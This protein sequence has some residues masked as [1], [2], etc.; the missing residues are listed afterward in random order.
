MFPNKTQK[1]SFHTVGAKGVQLY[2]ISKSLHEMCKYYT[3]L[4][5][6]DKA[7][8]I[9]STTNLEINIGKEK[10]Q[11]FKKAHGPH[12]NWSGYIMFMLKDAFLFTSV[13]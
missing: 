8:D 7:L 12:C 9:C 1:D 11:L 10:L 3:L 2:T 5:C 4:S 6:S 13:V